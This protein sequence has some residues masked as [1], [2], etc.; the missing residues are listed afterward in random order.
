MRT[1]IELIEELERQAKSFDGIALVMGFPEHTQFVWDSDGHQAEKVAK[2]NKFIQ[3]GGEPVGFVGVRVR[4]DVGIIYLRPLKQ[5]E[6]DEKT[7]A[8]L[9]KLQAIVGQSLAAKGTSLSA[10]KFTEGWVIDKNS[11]DPTKLAKSR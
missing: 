10:L 1:T 5:Y 4:E 6:T 9:M 11:T 7:A 3:L 2:L 8:Y